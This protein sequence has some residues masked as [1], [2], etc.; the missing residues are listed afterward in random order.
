[1]S[2]VGEA[3]LTDLAAS[4]CSHATW[5]P[6]ASLGGGDQNLAL[7]TSHLR[8]DGIPKATTGVAK[9]K[10]PKKV[11]SKRVLGTVVWFK[12][13]KGYGFISR[14][15]TQEDVFVHHTAITGKNPCTYRGSVDDGEM[16][17]FDVVQGEW[18][19]EAA[20]VTG[21]AGAPL[22]GSRY[23]A[24]RQRLRHFP[25]SRRAP[26]V[27]RHPSILATTSGPRSDLQPGSAPT[28]RQEGRPQQGRGPSYLLSRPRG[29][30]TTT[31]DPRH[32]PGISQELETEHSK[33]GHEVS[34]N[35]PQ[36]HPPRYGSCHPKNPHRCP[37]Q[38]PGTQG[39]NSN[40]E[41]KFRKSPIETPASV[42]VAKKNDAPEEENPSVMDAPSAAR[43]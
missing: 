1:M 35:L 25:P 13:K 12:E 30:G 4:F 8:G 24:H 40:R 38:V 33:S 34:S 17:E 7:D 2:E 15:D 28:A 39:Q 23:T 36:R 37:Q 43:A 26:S 11:I 29:R 14:Q 21:P 42:A 3:T 9:G 5:K 16:V 32:S 6:L 22:K 20:N 18:G 31:P 19:T 10:V 27:T 41:G